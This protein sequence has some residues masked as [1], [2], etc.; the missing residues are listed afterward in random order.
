MFYIAVVRW[1]NE[2]EKDLDIS[3]LASGF[4]V[5]VEALKEE[6]RLKMTYPFWLKDQEFNIIPYILDIMTDKIV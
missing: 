3:L 4:L 2:R 1:D 6:V 5:E